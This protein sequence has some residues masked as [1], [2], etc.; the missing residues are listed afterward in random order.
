V[1]AYAHTWA[2]LELK[3]NGKELSGEAINTE[4]GEL[5]DSFMIKKK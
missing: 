4:D 3:V 2:F 1:A 5:V